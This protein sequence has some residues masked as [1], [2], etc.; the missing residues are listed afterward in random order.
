MKYEFDSEIKQLE[1][2]IKWSV[3]YFPYSTVEE[4]GSKGN[5]PVLITVEGHCFEH[6]LLPSRNGHYLVYN[7]FIRQAVGKNIGDTVH[8][9]LEK[10]TKERKYVVPPHIEKA[11]NERGVLEQYLKQP[12]YL[13]REQVNFIEVA[14]KEETKQ[15]RLNKLIAILAGLK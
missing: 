6:T 3:F 2:K 5:I 4:L 15:N 14:K 11:L 1:G 13:K 8:V 9:T 12:D 10:D 7:E